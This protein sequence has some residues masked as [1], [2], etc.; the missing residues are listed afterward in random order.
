[1]VAHSSDLHTDATDSDS[2]SPDDGQANADAAAGVDAG[3]P[4]LQPVDGIYISIGDIVE[5]LLRLCTL[6]I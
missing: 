5:Y 6:S 4:A 3:V 1:M 2:N